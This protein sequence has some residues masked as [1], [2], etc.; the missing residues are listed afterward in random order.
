MQKTLEESLSQIFESEILVDGASRTDAGVHAMAQCARFAAKRTI[1]LKGLLYRLNEL[2]PRDMSVWRAWEVDETFHPRYGVQNKTYTYLLNG[3]PCRSALSERYAWQLFDSSLD[4]EAMRLCC[5]FLEGEH[6]FRSFSCGKAPEDCTVRRL[7]SCMVEPL[8]NL[9]WRVEL[10]AAGFL[11]R[12]AR[13]IVGT[14][15]EIGRRKIDLQAV[16]RL[17]GEPVGGSGGPTAPAHGLCLT[18]MVY[19]PPWDETSPTPRWPLKVK[20]RALGP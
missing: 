17:L 6:D 1:P 14:L 4:L 2:L 20:K 10:K 15:V 7:D 9:G 16:E 8:Q 3:G 13:M 11:N 18:E 12:M 5:S 19:P